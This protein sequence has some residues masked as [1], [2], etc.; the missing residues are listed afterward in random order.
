MNYLADEN[1]ASKRCIQEA[2]DQFQEH[3]Q[4][5]F[6]GPAG[7]EFEL[8]LKELT[9]WKG[10]GGR[11]NSYFSASQL[12]KDSVQ[13][14]LDSLGE[15]SENSTVVALGDLSALSIDEQSWLHEVIKKGEGLP[16]GGTLTFVFWVDN[17]KALSMDLQIL[18]RNQVIKVPPL[19]VRPGD[20]AIYSKFFL[21]EFSQDQ[22]R[23]DPPEFSG[24]AMNLLLHYPWKGNFSQLLKVLKKSIKVATSVPLS[25]EALRSILISLDDKIKVPLEAGNLEEFLILRQQ[26]ILEKYAAHHN[27]NTRE[28]LSRLGFD[29][30]G[31]PEGMGI[32][33]LD[34][35]YP[36][37]LE[38][39]RKT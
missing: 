10:E 18:L 11:S 17:L 32:D 27:I 9:H 4:L 37:L 19:S 13:E 22:G 39:S 14:N 34:L 15:N 33:Q 16:G 8:I 25:Y 35:L 5:F 12:R 6:T 30:S 3:S 28:V 20:I 7:S 23:Q 21:K 24:A 26:A 1:I 36:E 2:W 31:M 38:P 29:V